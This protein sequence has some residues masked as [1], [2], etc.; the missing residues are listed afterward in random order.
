MQWTLTFAMINIAWVFFRADYTRQPL[1]VFEQLLLG[2]GG[3]CNDILLSASCDNVL[4]VAVLSKFLAPV[5]VAVLRQVWTGAVF[6]LGVLLCVKLPSS[7]EMVQKECKSGGY[8][9]YLGVLFVWSFVCLSQISK[10]I[11]FNF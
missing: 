5:W 7:H 4:G 1:V 11:Y 8:F 6:L 3:W 2:G 9:L 10:F